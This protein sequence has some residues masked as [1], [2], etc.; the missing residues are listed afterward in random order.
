[1]FFGYLRQDGIFL[2]TI[3]DQVLVLNMMMIAE[4]LIKF[5]AGSGLIHVNIFLNV[6]VCKYV[7]KYYYI[8]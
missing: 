1:M 2:P 6:C 5:L 3:V 8:Q 7:H 4:H